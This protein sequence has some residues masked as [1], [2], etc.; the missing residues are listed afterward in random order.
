MKELINLSVA[1]DSS[2]NAYPSYLVG[3][4]LAPK[5]AVPNDKQCTLHA[6]FAEYIVCDQGQIS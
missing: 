6:K 4:I 1:D 3:H 2:S 5:L